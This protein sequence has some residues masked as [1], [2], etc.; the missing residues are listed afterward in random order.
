MNPVHLPLRSLALACLAL[1]HGAHAPAFAVPSPKV[2]AGFEDIVLG[3]VE[4]VEIRLLGRSLGLFAVKVTPDA[5][6]IEQPEAVAD[7][8]GLRQEAEAAQDSGVRAQVVRA[9]AQPMPRNGN[10]A[11]NGA[12]VVSAGSCGYL[13]TERAAVI[14]DESNG[15]M[16]LFLARAWLPVASDEE[17]R[18]HSLSG[19]AE[20]ALIHRQTAN[21]TSGRGY[22]NLT[23]TGAGALGVTDQ[24]YLG[25]NWAFIQADQDKKSSSTLRVDDLYYRH[26]F[27]RRFYAQAGR[28]DQR[29]LASPLGGNF[30]FSMLPLGRFDGARFG[31]TQA[32]VN[33]GVAAQG[34]P[35]T[36]LLSGDARVDAY[37]GNELLSTSYLRAGINDIDTAAF[38][39]GSYIVTLRIYENGVLSRTETAPFSKV[40]GGAESKTTQWF[41]QGGRRVEPAARPQAPEGGLSLQAGVRTPLPWNMF[42][43]SGVASLHGAAYNETKLDWRRAFDAGVLDSSLSFIAGSDGARGNSQ[44]ISFNNGVSWNLYRYQ[45]R[46]ASCERRDSVLARDI[47]C[48]DSLSASVSFPLGKWSS[49]AGYTYSNTIGRPLFADGLPDGGWPG[50]HPP[51]REHAPDRVSRAFQVGLTR[52]FSWQKLIFSSRFGAFHRAAGSTAAS[53]LGVYAGL[54]ISGASQTPAAGSKSTFSSAGTELRS[55]RNGPAQIGYNAN[56]TWMWQNGTYRELGADVSGVRDDSFSAAVRGR[57]DGR[58]GNLAATLADSYRRADGAHN[59]SLTGSY[60]SSFALGRGGLYFG[61]DSGRGEPAAALAVQV[62][63]NEQATGE[64][65]AEVAASGARPIKLGFG[66][67]TLLPLEGFQPS[68]AQ[69]NDAAASK[70]SSTVSVATG[71]AS[72]NYFLMPGKLVT[73]Q[74]AANVSY[75]YV[76]RALDADGI[77]LA[78]ASVLNAALPALDE[79]GGFVLEV[80]QQTPDLFLLDEGAVWRCPLTVRRQHDVIRFVGETS[81]QVVD[82]HAMPPAMRGQARVNRLLQQEYLSA[83]KPGAMVN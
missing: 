30:G 68:Q 53:D 83:G 70:A 45:M 26:D 28:M 23:A 17:R 82:A 9:L 39:E 69:V 29:N 51:N 27:D 1:I 57:V 25:L 10:L 16:E 60:T 35:L 76:G 80:G 31:T 81:C 22:R 33:L 56:Q 55:Q 43:T 78:G 8:L 62:A 47:G 50:A 63:P 34:S 64:A 44:L 14:F 75:T 3:Q 4:Q 48:Y 2:P 12:G 61:G 65:A 24:S 15:A 59:P 32:Y 18:Y 40:G 20:N 46:G 5:V 77:A 79:A 74:V 58:L 66:S 36:A 49:L 67:R 21:F 72:R 41:V 7:A 52:S 71:N 42:L 13:D 73:Q 38:P 11:C 37:R 19:S 54:T 6:S